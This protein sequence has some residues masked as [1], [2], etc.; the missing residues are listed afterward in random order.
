M[1]TAVGFIAAS[2]AAPNRPR[3]RSLST[4]W[5]VRTSDRA[6]SSSLL[7]PG[8]AHLPAPFLGQVL[9]PGDDVHLEGQPDAGNPGAQ[10]AQAHHPQGL[11]QESSAHGL[12]PA[13]FTRG[14]VLPRDVPEQPDDQSPCQ[15]RRG[16]AHAGGAADRHAPFPGRGHV[17]GR[18]PHAAGYQQPE[19]GQ[20][21]QQAPPER[22]PFAHHADHLEGLQPFGQGILVGP[23]GRGRP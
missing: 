5:M 10:L 2:S 16:S 15:L 4:R 11:A 9:A 18:V 19:V 3:V 22:R 20:A 23:G 21:L 13:A 14:P 7:D 12:L 1:S 8:Y 17:D 6:S